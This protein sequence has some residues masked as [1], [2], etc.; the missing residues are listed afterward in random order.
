MEM[1]WHQEPPA[2]QQEGAVLSVTAAPKTDFWRKTHDSG[3]RDNGHF[4]FTTVTG[5]FVAQVKL[6]GDYAAQYDQAGLMVRLDEA[7]WL[8]CGIEL[9]E[10]MQY[11]S[12]VVTRDWSDWSLLPLAPSDRARPVWIRVQRQGPTFAVH[13]SLDGHD[14]TMMRQAFLGEAATV[15]V[16]PMIASPTGSGFRVTFEELTIAHSSTAATDAP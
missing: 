16:G 15:N 8:K 3:V 11:A 14:Y 5:D 4:Y 9:A 7:H 1:R 13:Y 2:W 12:T 6:T 10:G